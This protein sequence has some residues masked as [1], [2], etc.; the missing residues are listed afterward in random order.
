MRA[1][2]CKR[3]QA[4]AFECLRL[5]VHT[6]RPALATCVAAA[7]GRARE[8]IRAAPTGPTLQCRAVPCPIPIP[9][10]ERLAHSHPPLSPS[11]LPSLAPTSAPPAPT[12]LPLKPPHTAPPRARSRSRGAPPGLAVGVAWAQSGI[13]GADLAKTPTPTT[14]RQCNSSNRPEFTS[15]KLCGRCRSAA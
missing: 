3:M 9:W 8:A 7:W 5:F 2:L 4:V 11:V 10:V 13:L 6:L 14:P 1:T 15:R 12:P